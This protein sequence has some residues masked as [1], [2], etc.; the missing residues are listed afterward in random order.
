MSINLPSN[1]PPSVT[2]I[3]VS[4][5]QPDAKIDQALSAGLRHFG[6]NQVQEA[7]RHWQH[8]RA[9]FTDLTLHLIGPLQSNKTK[10]AVA[11]FDVIQTVDRQKIADH[12]S[13][14][15]TAQQRFLPCFIQVN[16]G[17][18]IQKSGISFDALNNFYDYCTKQAG[19]NIIGLM[20]IPPLSE[21][22]TPYFQKLKSAADALGLS[23]LSMGM[24]DDYQQAIDCGATHIRVGSALFGDR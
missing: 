3:A 4:K 15:M 9:D 19:L 22:P 11:L 8:R 23:Q 17:D 13:A 5:K 2:L 12:L 20:G 24:S 7:Y 14:E 16:L 21:N 1:I 6:E 10:E 18:E